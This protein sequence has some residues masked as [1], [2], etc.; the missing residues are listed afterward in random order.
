MDPILRR[1][2]FY[3]VTSAIT[4]LSV[5]GRY[6]LTRDWPVF[7]IIPLFMPVWLLS[8][9]MASESDERYTF[10]RTLP[11]PDRAVVRTKFTLILLSAAFQWTLMVGAAFARMDEGIAGPWTLV[12][13]T[14]LCVFGLL[15]VAGFQIGVWRFGYSAMK[16]V[17]IVTIIVGILAIIIHLASLKTSD[18]WPALSQ[19][20]VVEWLARAPWLSSAVLFALALV[21]Y[22]GLMRLGVRV[23][24]ASEAHL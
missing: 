14:L 10:L 12:Y 23:K 16:P 20:G 13:L 18:D 24:A 15:S 5:M 4:Y 9:M 19:S 1:S 22:R 11:V 7:E 3:Y 6:F 17:L 21:A 2:S 8:A